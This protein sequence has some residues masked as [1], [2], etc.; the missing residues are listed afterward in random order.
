[1]ILLEPGNRILGE[2]VTDSLSEDSKVEP[3]EVKL[4]D[5]DDVTYQVKVDAANLKLMQVSMNL[6]CYHQI[7]DKG[8]ESAV[9]RVYGDMVAAEAE[10]GFD[11]TI[12]VPLEENKDPGKLAKDVTLLKQNT[13]GGVFDHYFTELLVGK[14][15]G[16][17]F[18]FDLRGDTTLYFFPRKDRVVVIFAL[19]F[20][21]D[22]DKTIAKVFMQE[23]VDSR[24][25]VARAPPVSWGANPPKELE[26]FKITENEGNLG[27]ISF[28]ILKSHL[29]K[30]KKETVISVLQVFRNYIQYHIK[31]SKSYFHQRMR[32]RVRAL[33]KVLNRARFD[34][35]QAKEKK[36]AG[37]KTFRRS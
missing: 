7:K 20:T 28:A 34:A 35:D 23:F 31:C 13:V 16:E 27:Y 9:K 30:G 3:M 24:R 1:M 10:T 11:I 8:A 14:E 29:D 17:P 18:K 4:C 2:T 6:P 25:R 21:E 19:D 37:G 12:N 36:T 22:V 5:F 33:L 15:P 32:A 26:H